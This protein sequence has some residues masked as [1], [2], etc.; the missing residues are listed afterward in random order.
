MVARIDSARARGE[1]MNDVCDPPDDGSDGARP[2]PYDPK[3]LRLSQ[4]LGEGQDVRRVIVSMPVRKPARQEFFR[5]HPDL[6]MWLETAVLELKEERLTFLVEPSLA[7]YLPGEA[8]PKLLVLAISSH[9]APFLWPIKLP[10]ERGRHDEWNAV[11]LEAAER[12][13]TRWIRL[14]ANIGAGTYD[15]LE[16]VAAFPEP[17]WPDMSLQKVLAMAFKDR[18]IDSLDHPVLKRLRGEI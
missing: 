18:F 16:A 7:P 13:R 12:A 14:T 10:D 9:Q 11:A 17:Q 1:G 15:V 4:R 3:R 2:N 5:T 6:D 8:V